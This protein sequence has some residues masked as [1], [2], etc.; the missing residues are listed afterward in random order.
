MKV[1]RS[2][3]KRPTARRVRGVRDRLR[4]IYGVA[5]AQPHA[6]PVD[7]LILT[8]LSQSTNDRNR[9]VAFL[10]L[11]ERFA[12]WAHVRDAPLEDVENAIQPGGL[13]KQKSV[14]IQAILRALPDPLP[15]GW[16]NDQARLCCAARRRAQDGR[17]RAPV[18]LRRARHPGRHARVARRHQARP[19]PPWRRL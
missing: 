4:E 15:D 1:A 5:H 7:E 17:L 18:R 9:D 3:F 14:R 2:D 10:R 12:G 19:L 13:H 16:L 8:V 6:A 11:R